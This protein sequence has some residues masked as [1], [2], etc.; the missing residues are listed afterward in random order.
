MSQPDLWEDAGAFHYRLLPE[1]SL[2]AFFTEERDMLTITSD[3]GKWWIGETGVQGQSDYAT[4]EEAKAAG[5]EQIANLEAAQDGILLQEAGLNSSA[6]KVVY[7]DG[8]RFERV[9]G[10]AAIIAQ[11][12]QLR[13]RW[14]A[15]GI[16]DEPVA[17]DLNSVGAALLALDALQPA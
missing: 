4:L 14:D 16:A 2:D 7:R 11:D 13:Q 1:N 10:T 15:Y 3:H 8:L 5:D 6:W 17:M 9:D 12:Q